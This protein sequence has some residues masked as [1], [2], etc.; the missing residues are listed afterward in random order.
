[1]VYYV[2]QKNNGSITEFERC[3][4]TIRRMQISDPENTYIS[5][6]V[7]FSYLAF[8][9]MGDIEREM[10]YDLLCACDALIVVGEITEKVSGEIELAEKLNI[11]VLYASEF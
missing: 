9:E 3:E 6:S 5:P 10:R 4:E 11:E 1:M 7:T 8:N 2:T